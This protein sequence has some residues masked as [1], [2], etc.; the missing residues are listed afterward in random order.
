M[1]FRTS[2]GWRPSQSQRTF[3]AAAIL[4][5]SSVPIGQAHGATTKKATTKRAAPAF[6]LSTDDAS[7][8]VG[9]NSA[10]VVTI[11]ANRR[12][13]FPGAIRLSASSPRKGLTVA[14][15]ENPL[16][17]DDTDITVIAQPTTVLGKTR[18]TLTAANGNVVS[19]L[20][21][22]VTVSSK[23][24]DYGIP[25]PGTPATT[26]PG[27]PT[28]VSSTSVP[29]VVTPPTTIAPSPPSTSTPTTPT[30]PGVSTTT[31]VPTTI[32]ST[33][34]STTTTS[35]TLAP[36]T[37][38]GR[39]ASSGELIIK[40]SV[41]TQPVCDPL[42]LSTANLAL[43]INNTGTSIRT[44]AIVTPQSCTET[45]KISVAP[46]AV[47]SR[48]VPANALIVVRSTS[49]GTPIRKV[50]RVAAG[51]TILNVGAAVTYTAVCRSVGPSASFSL[52]DGEQYVLTNIPRSECTV[53]EDNGDNPRQLTDNWGAPHDG[54]VI[55]QGRPAGCGDPTVS[56]PV[57]TG[58]GCYGEV[59][60]IY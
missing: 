52:A 5:I 39:P 21:I 43:T 58:N 60:A 4:L 22:S 13:G 31:G 20:V 30:T 27:T 29:L 24:P 55:V 44:Y 26:G 48:F 56:T 32:A 41:T 18:I 3:V 45:A 46:G 57:G 47:T 11:S 23:V 35:S 50:F 25:I 34:T 54:I 19:R 2:H 1:N 12:A 51:S 7:I 16:L 38:T 53:T 36:T 9:R 28:L 10:T 33:T 40:R 42:A 17:A 59:V 15:D 6:R 49:T 8:I 14:F 37:T